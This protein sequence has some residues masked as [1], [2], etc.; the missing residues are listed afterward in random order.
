M[1]LDAHPVQPP[2]ELPAGG[3]RDLIRGALE[4]FVRGSEPGQLIPSE[5]ALAEQF[6][7]ARMTV[8]AAVD[9]LEAMGLIRRVQGRGAYVQH[10]M[11]AQPEVLRSFTQDMILRGMVP[12]SREFHASVERAS[13]YIAEKLGVAEHDEVYMIERVRTADGLPMAVERTNLSAAAFPQ[14]LD[15]MR[16]GD[17][18][19]DL[20]STEYGVHVDSAE[21][22]FT[23]AQLDE[24]D[25]Q[26]LG[27][28]PGAAAFALT[29]TSRDLTGRVVE[30][31]RSLYRGDRYVIRTQVS[32]DRATSRLSREPAEP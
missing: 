12:G 2:A 5:R 20:L 31:G 6:S 32:K 24:T 14:L 30:F 8:R 18:L 7:V 23:I 4:E 19:Y 1:T 13:S 22:A 28:T 17:S 15:R 3:K 26:R 16:G 25:A 21:Q 9:S 10:P 29:Q 11:L 27:T